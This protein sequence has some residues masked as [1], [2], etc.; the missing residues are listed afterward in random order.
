MID[1]PRKRPGMSSSPSLTH[2]GSGWGDGVMGAD[3]AIGEESACQRGGHVAVSSACTPPRLG[4]ELDAPTHRW[5]GGWCRG[6]PAWGVPV[7]SPQRNADWCPLI[8]SLIPF[9]QDAFSLP[10]TGRPANAA[11]SPSSDIG[12][13]ETG[14]GP[15]A[16]G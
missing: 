2:S 6:S 4:P 13:V 10:R 12:L 3:E 8:M 5:R 14:D 9:A 15:C 1:P 7:S 16:C 11:G